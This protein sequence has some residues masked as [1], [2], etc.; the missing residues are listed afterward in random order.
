MS[1]ITG[2]GHVAIKV[3][4]INRALRFYADAFGFNELMRL[5]RDDGSL[6]LVYLR[7]TDTQ[8]LEVFPEARGPQA[9]DEDANGLNHICLEVDDIEAVIAGIEAAG[10]ELFRPLTTGADGNRQAWVKD[11]DGNRIE[12][13]QMNPDGMQARAI[14]ALRAGA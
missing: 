13:M 9:P 8:F 7:I 14:A 11:P 5:E 12:L 3:A 1:A 6:W 4:D 2:I 10:V